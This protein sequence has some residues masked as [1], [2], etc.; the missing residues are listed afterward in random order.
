[1]QEEEG[2]VTASNVASSN[3]SASHPPER[4][5]V[6][7]CEPRRRASSPK[8][9]P[10]TSAPPGCSRRDVPGLVATSR[11]RV[12]VPAPTASRSGSATC[13]VTRPASE[14][15]RAS[16]VVQPASSNASNA[17]GSPPRPEVWENAPPNRRIWSWRRSPQ[18]LATLRA[19]GL[20][21]PLDAAMQSSGVPAMACSVE[22]R[23]VT[24]ASRRR[25]PCLSRPRRERAVSRSRRDRGA[26][27]PSH[28]CSGTCSQDFAIRAHRRACAAI[29]LRT[30]ATRCTRC[31]CRRRRS[32]VWRTNARAVIDGVKTRR[33][34]AGERLH[35]GAVAAMDGHPR[36]ASALRP[37]T[38]ALHVSPSY[39]KGSPPAPRAR[40]SPRRARA[41]RLRGLRADVV[42]EDLRRPEAERTFPGLRPPETLHPSQLAPDDA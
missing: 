21:V 18:S 9:R 36:V 6:G 25:P 10:T 37:G 30:D 1:M 32:R 15:G 22:Q 12:P 31:R 3:G 19:A 23:S 5:D 33:D 38:S 17:M 4:T 7:A 34:L 41:E 40:S 13:V 39:R 11:T 29:G 35:F 8:S 24:F 16:F 14:S 20:G 28:G 27:P 2:H 26:C 42:E